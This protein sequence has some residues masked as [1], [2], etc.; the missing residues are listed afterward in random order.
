MEKATV[1]VVYTLELP[2]YNG[3]SF[4]LPKEMIR[5]M[6]RETYAGFVTMVNNLAKKCYIF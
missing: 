4:I 3:T 5:P 6:V 2:D 1:P